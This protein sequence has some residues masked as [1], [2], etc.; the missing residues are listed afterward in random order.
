MCITLLNGVHSM[1]S[2]MW[3]TTL[4][5]ERENDRANLDSVK[6]RGGVLI[7]ELVNTQTDFG[8]AKLKDRD[9]IINMG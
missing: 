8:M 1:N 4:T 7:W 6:C 9:L 2:E 5:E 3:L